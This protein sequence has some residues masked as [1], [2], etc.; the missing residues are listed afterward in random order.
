MKDVDVRPIGV[1]GVGGVV[2]RPHAK[3]FL[4]FMW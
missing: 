1:V 3:L 2:T 4:A